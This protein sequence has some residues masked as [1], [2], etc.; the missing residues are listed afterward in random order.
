MKHNL[1]QEMSSNNKLSHSALILDDRR[2]GF[3]DI[4][5]QGKN[6]GEGETGEK[7]GSGFRKKSFFERKDPQYMLFCGKT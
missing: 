5:M 2:K 6:P 4:N 3:Y 1:N 7:Y